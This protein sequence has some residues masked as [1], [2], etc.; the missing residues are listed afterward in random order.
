MITPTRTVIAVFIM[1]VLTIILSTFPTIGIGD[2]TF[3]HPVASWGISNSISVDNYSFLV[4]IFALGFMFLLILVICNAMVAYIVLKNINAIYKTYRSGQGNRG[5]INMKSELDVMN[6][7]I[8]KERHK[9]QIHLFRVFGGLQLSNFLTWFLSAIVYLLVICGIDL[10]NIPIRF[11]VFSTAMFNLQV[12]LHPLIETL[13]IKEV[14]DPVKK[15]IFHS[16]FKLCHKSDSF[17]MAGGRARDNVSRCYCGEHND[18]RWCGNNIIISKLRLF[19]NVFNTAILPQ[20]SD[21]PQQT[22]TDSKL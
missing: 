6:N 9:K 11:L 8:R 20:D 2:M 16:C 12:F 17:L 3:S 7:R 15:I 5:N 22:I 18:V 4:I 19:C 14:R 13:L 21:S 1:W 10:Y